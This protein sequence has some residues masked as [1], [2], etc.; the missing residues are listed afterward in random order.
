MGLKIGMV[1]CFHMGIY[2]NY[3]TN[4]LDSGILQQV[5]YRWYRYRMV[6]LE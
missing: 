3:N 4:L 2:R 6:L 1:M 5:Y